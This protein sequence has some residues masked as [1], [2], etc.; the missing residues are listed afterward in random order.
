MLIRRIPEWRAFSFRGRS[1]AFEGRRKNGVRC[2]MLKFFL[3]GARWK[4]SW[5]I[6]KDICKFFVNH[7]LTPKK[8]QDLNPLK[9][10]VL[11]QL[12]IHTKEAKLPKIKKENVFVHHKVQKFKHLGSKLSFNKLWKFGI[13]KDTTICF[14]FEAKRQPLRD[15]KNWNFKP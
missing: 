10:H 1:S 4:F 2:I 15:T 14:K 7:I 9:F 8:Y 11:S 6:L 13:L 12:L 5:Q 3:N